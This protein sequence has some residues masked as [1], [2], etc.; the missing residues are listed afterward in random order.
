M[1]LDQR[2]VAAFLTETF[3][4]NRLQKNASLVFPGYLVNSLHSM[5]NDAHT[6]GI[7]S[8]FTLS[9]ID[10]REDAN[11]MFLRH[12]SLLYGLGNFVNFYEASFGVGI[13]MVSAE[14]L[15]FRLVFDV[16]LARLVV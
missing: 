6:R 15:L 5:I 11:S 12:L 14:L 9:S 1:Y 4:I 2:L 10:I 3:G 8:T 7:L 13:L 16:D